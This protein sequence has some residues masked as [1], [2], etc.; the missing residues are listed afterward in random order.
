MPIWWRPPRKD[1]WQ[2][3]QT[4]TQAG[5]NRVKEVCQKFQ[6]LGD[7][8][9]AHVLQEQ[10]VEE[11]LAGNKQKARQDQQSLK[12][13]LTL[14]EQEDA[15]SC[16]PDTPSKEMEMASGPSGET[17]LWAGENEEPA[18]RRDEV[19]IL[20]DRPRS[21]HPFVARPSPCEEPGGAD[22]DQ[23]PAPGPPRYQTPTSALAPRHPRQRGEPVWRP[24]G[25]A[26]RRGVRPA[27]TDRDRGEGGSR[28]GPRERRSDRNAASD[29]EARPRRRRQQRRGPRDGGRAMSEVG[30][31]PR[32]GKDRNHQRTAA[33]MDTGSSRHLLTVD[34][35][36]ENLHHSPLNPP[37]GPR[38]DR[39][40]DANGPR[41]LATEE[42]N[43]Q[44]SLDEQKHP[45]HR[46]AANEKQVRHP[47][48]NGKHG[49]HPLAVE[50]QVHRPMADQRNVHH[51]LA[52]EKQD[53]QPL[54]NG[55]H[56]NHPLAVERQVRYPMADQRNIHHPLAV[57]R[58]VRYPMADQRKVHHPLAVEGQVHRPL[59]SG[60]QV[61]QPL[62]ADQKRVH[63]PQAVGWNQ[64]GRPLPGNPA[65]A[66]VPAAGGRGHPLRPGAAAVDGGGPPTRGKARVK[67]VH[68]RLSP[69]PASGQNPSANQ[70]TQPPLDTRA[71]QARL[72]LASR[73][74]RV[75]FPLDKESDGQRPLAFDHPPAQLATSAG[76]PNAIQYEL[77]SKE[78][79]A[80]I[81]YVAVKRS[82]GGALSW[83]PKPPPSSPAHRHSPQAAEGRRQPA[84]GPAS[85]SNDGPNGAVDRPR[86]EKTAA[87]SRHKVLGGGGVAASS[88]RREG[89][90]DPR[91]RDGAARR[92]GPHRRAQ[93]A[94]P[95]HQ[96]AQDDRWDPAADKGRGPENGLTA[97]PWC[98]DHTLKAMQAVELRKAQLRKARTAGRHL[99]LAQDEEFAL[100]LLRGEMMALSV[101]ER[102]MDRERRDSRPEWDRDRNR[103]DSERS[104]EMPDGK[105]REAVRSDSPPSSV[106]VDWADDG[107]MSRPAYF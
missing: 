25:V 93:S 55:K 15:H 61:R 98:S 19:F 91:R 51:P 105:K 54:A 24:R 78:A 106:N 71:E 35:R 36:S 84:R 40:K 28:D 14:Q 65:A 27:V 6:I 42:K 81:D 95:D 16:D 43:A 66:W 37:E 47:L 29:S 79:E 73:P 85:R 107:Q 4:E 92:D 44:R 60:K 62:A 38:Q 94:D 87:V 10:E 74:K 46:L 80:I 58:Q 88:P 48:V 82:E 33:E 100:N 17:V 83:S 39:W 1:G 59:A 56:G 50:R 86:A 32:H 97:N 34:P 3:T 7:Q 41:P 52:N 12:V 11:H 20:C 8:T 26:E 5:K 75:H 102:E 45:H 53:R 63:W 90:L 31:R 96:R 21:R 103:Q 23:R 70:T 77:G 13:A 49:Q 69:P 99:Q 2:L 30:R 72:P 104:M 101:Q 18:G 9:V 67:Q 57:E 76:P 68:F 22:G 89:P 64:D